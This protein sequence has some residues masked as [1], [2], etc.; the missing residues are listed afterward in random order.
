MLLTAAV[1]MPG[2][3]TSAMYVVVLERATRLKTLRFPTFPG[4]PSSHWKASANLNT[5]NPYVYIRSLAVVSSP[6]VAPPCGILVILAGSFP[7]DLE[8]L[9]TTTSN[10]YGN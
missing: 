7:L 1:L 5:N 10:W 8:A 9:D 4:I 3:Q 6:V 2:N